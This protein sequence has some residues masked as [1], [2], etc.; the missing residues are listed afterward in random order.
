MTIEIPRR[1]VPSIQPDERSVREVRKEFAKVLETARVSIAGQARNQV[2]TFLKRNPPRYLLE[3]FD[4]RFFLTDVKQIPELRF[5]LAYVVQPSGKANRYRCFPRIFYK[6]LSLAWRSASHFSVDDGEIW[7]GKGDVRRTEANGYETIESFEATTDLPLEMQTALEKILAYVKKPGGGRQLLD[8][9]LRKSHPDRVEPYSDFVQP[10]VAAQKNPSNLIAGGKSI[11][12]FVRK[13]D[14][15]SLKIL[16]GY[17]PDFSKPGIVEHS[18]SE[19]K[20]YGGRLDRFRIL[21]TN[22]V[23]QYFFIAAPK[24]VW[25][26]PPQATTTQISSYGVRTIDVIAD[27]DLFIPGYEYHHYEETPSG[28]ELYSQIPP[29]FAGAVCPHDDAKADASPWLD[30]ISLIQEF[31]KRLM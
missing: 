5:Y 17:E 9:V 15:T 8:M 20:L 14:P 1:I 25:I 22:R 3:L 30:K 7:V 27:D 18:F 19:S 24:H 23:I 16:K 12:R 10:R 26:L 31:R 4:T 28:T 11:A 29:G 2:E 21:S 13:N 6:D